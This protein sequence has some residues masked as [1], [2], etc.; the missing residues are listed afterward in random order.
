MSI[1]SYLL[2]PLLSSSISFLIF[3]PTLSIVEKRVLNPPT[4]FVEVSI[5]SFQLYKFVAL[6]ILVLLLDLMFLCWDCM[7]PCMFV[8]VN[9]II[10][11]YLSYCFDY[12]FKLFSGDSNI[13][14]HICVAFS[15]LSWEPPSSWYNEWFFNETWTFWVLYYETLALI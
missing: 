15:H 11:L 6:Y 12:C 5:F 13:S 3:C 14:Y 10:I 2:M 4:T 7:F 8:S 9:F 1:V